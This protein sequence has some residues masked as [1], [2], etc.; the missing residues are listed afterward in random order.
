M[1]T[2]VKKK[3]AMC[4]ATVTCVTTLAVGGGGTALAV[5]SPFT[6]VKSSDWFSRQ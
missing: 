6:D 2:K 3:V 1:K 5:E 4:L